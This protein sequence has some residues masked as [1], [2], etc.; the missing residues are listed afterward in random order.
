M[1]F[2]I[3]RSL[4]AYA[5]HRLFLHMACHIK[6]FTDFDL[7]LYNINLLIVKTDMYSLTAQIVCLFYLFSK[8]QVFYLI[9]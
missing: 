9:I 4:F 8:C 1:H 3:E 5:S 2:T 6:L 7:K